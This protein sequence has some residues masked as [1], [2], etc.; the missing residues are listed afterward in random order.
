MKLTKKIAALLLST[1]I[2]ASF[3]ACG[4]QQ[5]S[6]EADSTPQSSRQS[7]SAQ[8]STQIANPWI[9]VKDQADAQEQAGFTIQLPSALPDGF[10]DPEFQVIPGD[11]LEAD[12]MGENDAKLCVRKAV[13][14]DD[15]SGDYNEYDTV[16]TV[17]VEDVD[18]TVK[19]NG[20]SV[21]LAVWN[22][23]SDAWSIGI[24]GS[25]GLTRQ[26]METLIAAVLE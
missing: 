2:L 25:D 11:I 20:D 3:A 21:S 18:V 7:Q 14:T 12:Y 17:M 13:G 9:A 19:G 8:E 4:G 15:P 1:C 24:Y 23:G 22:N 16:E 6:S 26:E 5:T 10:G